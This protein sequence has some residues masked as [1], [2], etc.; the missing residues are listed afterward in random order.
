MFAKLSSADP[1]VREKL[2]T[3]GIY[4]TE[5]GFYRELAAAETFPIRVPRPYL[6]LYDETT[7]SSILLL[8]DLGQARFGDNVAGC[9][10][11]DARIAVRQLALLHAHFWES[12]SLQSFPWLRSLVDDADARTALYRAMLPRFEQRWAE[13]QRPSLL[14]AARGFADVLPPSS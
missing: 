7:G 8:E 11:A 14:K 3:V 13:F 9:S 10:P 1:G 5:A 4:A 6:S 12:P 2:R